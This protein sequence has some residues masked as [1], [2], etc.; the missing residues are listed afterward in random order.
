MTYYNFPVYGFWDFTLSA[1]GLNDADD[2]LLNGNLTVRWEI[3]D[4]NT[5]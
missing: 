1:D 5:G 3:Y 4:R 2:N